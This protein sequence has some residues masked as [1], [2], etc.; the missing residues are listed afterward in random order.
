MGK[1]R[2]SILP[3]KNHMWRQLIGK[4]ESV[5]GKIGQICSMVYIICNIKNHYHIY[6]TEK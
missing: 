4:R 1:G 5:D 6:L 2:N 3:V